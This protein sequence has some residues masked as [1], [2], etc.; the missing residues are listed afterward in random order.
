MPPG[1]DRGDTEVRV[2]LRRAD[3]WMTVGE[4]SLVVYVG[5][6][7]RRR[8]TA[9]AYQSPV[10]TLAEGAALRGIEDDGSGFTGWCFALEASAYDDSEKQVLEW[11]PVVALP[12][13]GRIETRWEGQGQVFGAPPR[14]YARGVGSDR[15][16]RGA[17]ALAPCERIANL[18]HALEE[19]SGKFH[20]TDGELELRPAKHSMRASEG[21]FEVHSGGP[22]HH[23]SVDAV[24]V[25][26][27]R[28]HLYP[29][30]GRQVS[31][32]GRVPM[33]YAFA[34]HSP[35][36]FESEPYRFERAFLSRH[37][38][39]GLEHWY[40][41]AHPVPDNFAAAVYLTARAGWG[42]TTYPVVRW[43]NAPDKNLSFD[44]KSGRWE[45]NGSPVV[46]E[47]TL[48][49]LLERLGCR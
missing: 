7:H 10:W 25:D 8:V 20:G 26:T 35:G 15:Q 36:G 40:E 27:R 30:A 11:L 28:G 46:T 41:A 1:V 29:P 43:N 12:G 17:G 23:T 3:T 48:P 5:E 31:N 32:G 49:A 24:R 13:A 4:D 34:S 38:R 45:M 9:T 18:E 21:D 42:K 37:A 39:W 16:Y 44:S 47:A 33:M 19:G 14:Y 6:K 2:Q 22:P